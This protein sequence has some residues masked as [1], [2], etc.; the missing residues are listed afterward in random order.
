M[1]ILETLLS[2]LP[3]GWR[4]TDVHVGAN[5]VLSLA[6][7]GVGLRRAGVAA[8]PNETALDARFQI[9]HYP[10]DE[11]A[12]VVARDLRSTDMTAAAV[13]LATFNALSQPDESRLTTA[14]AADWLSAQCVRRR[15]AIFGRF[16]FIDAEIRPRARRVWVF[17]QQ[18]QADELD[19]RAIQTVL[20]QA[21]VVAITGSSVINHTIDAI[22]PHIRPGTTVVLLGPSTPLSVKLFDNGID[23]LFGVRV[24]DLQGAIDSV[25]AG[26]GFQKMAG[27]QRVSLFRQPT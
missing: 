11:K 10:L 21:D 6:V 18:P 25:I 12:E 23:A 27:L 5:W 15:I 3:A 20:P 19:S 9:G 24:V 4:V 2:D 22:L 1:T 13:G 16:P 7:S 26:V 14:D 17:E 8:A